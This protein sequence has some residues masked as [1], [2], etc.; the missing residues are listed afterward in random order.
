MQ[1]E[2][3]LEIGLG[4]CT[5]PEIARILQVPSHKVRRWIN[6][7]WDGELGKEFESR[8]SW[9]TNQSKAVSFHT[10]IEF[11]VMIQFAEAG[12][13]T[14][15]VLKAH[16]T[17]AAYYNTAFPFAFKKVLKGMSTDG[18]KVYFE[19]SGCII[20]ADGT[21]QLNLEFVKLLFKKIDFDS[22]QLA[23]R[24]W[25]MGKESAVQVDPKR[26]FGH[27]V[28]GGHNIYP[29]TIYGMYKA[30]DEVDFI[31]FLYKLTPQEVNDAIDYYDAA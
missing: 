4:I 19:D 22:D 25:P 24:F 16:K 21:K 13:K 11:Y 6:R 10:L 27:P 31:A 12:V 3:Q 29:E 17:L 7:Y 5:P 18:K 9:E 30:G 20:T 26:K 28:I 23:S 2:N 8:Y 1:F 14:R 15:E